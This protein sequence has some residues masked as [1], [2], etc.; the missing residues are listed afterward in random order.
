[1]SA[2]PLQFLTGLSVAE[3]QAAQ[4]WWTNLTAAT[5]GEIV[6]LW[7]R[8]R[9]EC[10]FG[11]NRDEAGNKVPFVIGGRFIPH[12]DAW[13]MDEWFQS[14]FEYLLN[15]T[16]SAPYVVRT[17][18]FGCTQHPAARAC[19]AAGFIPADFQ[20]PLRSQ[21]CPMRKLLNLTPGQ[22]LQTISIPNSEVL[23]EHSEP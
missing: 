13:R 1:M 20:C 21:D 12:D 22:S 18:H 23:H 14:H 4:V 3:A 15:H 8:R 16:E 17:F 9:D 19:L 2:L 11:V 6:D 5:Q 10:F 7:D